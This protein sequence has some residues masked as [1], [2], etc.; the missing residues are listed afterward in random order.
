MEHGK[1]E[2]EDPIFDSNFTRIGGPSWGSCTVIVLDIDTNELVFAG[3]I[4]E[5]KDLFEK[6]E[7]FQQIFD[8][9]FEGMS[10]HR[11][12]TRNGPLLKGKMWGDGWRG[13]F[14]NLTANGE[15]ETIGTYVAKE[16]FQDA[17]NRARRASEKA[18]VADKAAGQGNSAAAQKEAGKLADR[19]QDAANKA[20][21]MLASWVEY[22]KKKEPICKLYRDSF[23]SLAPLILEQQTKQHYNL[24]VPGYGNDNYRPFAASRPFAACIADFSESVDHLHKDYFSNLVFTWG[25][26][27]IPVLITASC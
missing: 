5:S 25:T 6:R 21:K 8:Y 4:T 24:G 22:T 3:R 12:V 17:A 1:Y 2:W 14:G 18:A 19:A 23:L 27:P 13:G 26:C 16:R 15:V 11:E 10:M 20:D 9:A 7:T